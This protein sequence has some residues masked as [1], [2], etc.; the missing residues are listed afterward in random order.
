M[1]PADVS[2]TYD[3]RL[4]LGSWIVGL[5]SLASISADRVV[6]WRK[7]CRLQIW[8]TY[9][10]GPALWTPYN[11]KSVSGSSYSCQ[12]KITSLEHIFYPPNL[13]WLILH[14]QIA[15]GLRVHCNLEQCFWCKRISSKQTSCKDPCPYIV[16]C[17]PNL[18]PTLPTESLYIK[19]VQWLWNKFL[20]HRSR[21]RPYQNYLKTNLS[22]PY[23]SYPWSYFFSCF[24]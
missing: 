16:S 19:D 21:S 8:C 17:W 4:K 14:P 2:L 6:I 1:A 22:W 24:S 10:N 9:Y 11:D 5:L 15:L 20:G 3:L 18:F 7:T 12:S 23:I 13:I